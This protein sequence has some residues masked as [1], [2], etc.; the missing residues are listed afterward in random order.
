MRGFDHLDLTRRV[1]RAKRG[2][3]M[4][5]ICLGVLVGAVVFWLMDNYGG[6]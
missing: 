3:R 5:Y 1:S 4:C 6:F 2:L